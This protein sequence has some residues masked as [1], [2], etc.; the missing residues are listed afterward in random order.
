MKHI[1]SILAGIIVAIFEVIFLFPVI[2]LA[3]CSRIAKRPID[4]GL[5]PQPL[6]NNVYHK[7]SLMLQG[8][9]AETFVRTTWHTTKQFDFIGDAYLGNSKITNN[10]I[11][12]YMV[13][14]MLFFRVLFRYKCLFIYFNGGPLGSAAWLFQAIEPRLYKLA[15]IK[16]VVMPYGADIQAMSLSG[17]LYFKHTVSKDYPYHRILLKKNL[18]DIHRWSKRGDWV[19]SGCDW[20]DYMH[21]WN[22]LQLAHF[23]IDVEQWKTEKSIQ[24]QGPL[25]VLHAPNH[26]AIK[27][28][29]HLRRAIKELQSEGY[30]IELVVIQKQPNEV[31]R[32]TMEEVDLI[33]D[34]FVIGWYA[35][36]AIE[37]MAMERP[38]LCYLRHDLLELYLK[39]DLLK[40]EEMPLINTGL[41]E[42]KDKLIWCY[43]NREELRRIGRKGRQYIL[44]HHSLEFIGSEFASI[45]T[46]I[47]VQPTL[48]Q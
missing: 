46:Q 10:F 32:K 22:T 12:R 30:E 1:N 28:T 24:I 6:I 9:S 25:K 31:I 38:V 34:Q 11:T 36:F 8:Y 3:F 47:G 27:G 43:N 4:I 18:S 39:A 37:G 42:I 21:H 29:D 41:L 15:N 17:D 40:A 5:G 26:T 14:L 13:V 19:I 23:S 48:K 35:M 16:T 20:V 33:A 7:R 44:K 2:L 45:L